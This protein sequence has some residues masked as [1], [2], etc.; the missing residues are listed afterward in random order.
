M[1]RGTFQ[2]S[3]NQG[4]AEREGWKGEHVGLNRMSPG[5]YA[6]VDL[7]SGLQ[8]KTIVAPQKRAVACAREVDAL[9]FPVEAKSSMTETNH[10]MLRIGTLTEAH[11]A[12]LKAVL[13]LKP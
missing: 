10:G 13:D 2:V 1:K 12:Y 8:I 5:M 7:Y 11:R 9:D 4:L 3:T 6:L